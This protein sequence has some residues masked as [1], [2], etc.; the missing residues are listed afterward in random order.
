MMNG[1]GFARN[2]ND[3]H[4]ELLSSSY[5]RTSTFI[6]VFVTVGKVHCTGKFFHK[7]KF[8]CARF[9]EMR[10]FPANQDEDLMDNY[11]EL[12]FPLYLIAF[13]FFGGKKTRI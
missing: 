2:E 1:R 11:S 8:S 13:R 9:Q 10:F 12:V 4:D 7:N 5:C 6:S 3:S